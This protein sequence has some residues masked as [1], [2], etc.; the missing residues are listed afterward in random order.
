MLHGRIYEPVFLKRHLS[1]RPIYDVPDAFLVQSY[2][3]EG[4]VYAHLTIAGPDKTYHK[5][6][7]YSGREGRFEFDRS[8]EAIPFTN[9]FEKTVV[10]DLNMLFV[11]AYGRLLLGRNRSNFFL[12]SP[13]EDRWLRLPLPPTLKQ[14]SPY[15][16]SLPN[17]RP[18]VTVYRAVSRGNRW[19]PN[20]F[21]FSI[22]T[23]VHSV[24]DR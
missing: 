24:L 2:D 21:K 4:T 20:K 23:P 1:P 6:P 3:S 11:A 8:G 22:Q 5:F 7:L 14:G 19:L 10:H 9:F 13:E 16:S 12:C 17:R 18:P 15:R